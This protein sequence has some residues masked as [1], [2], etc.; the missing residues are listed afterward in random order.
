MFLKK[1]PVSGVIIR[2]KCNDKIQIDFFYFYC[3][4]RRPTLNSC[5]WQ[6]KGF[7]AVESMFGVQSSDLSTF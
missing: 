1:L 7:Y 3:W 5:R 4:L 6:N 2:L